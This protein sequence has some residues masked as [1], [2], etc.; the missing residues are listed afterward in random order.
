MFIRP[1]SLDKVFGFHR[2]CERGSGR[3]A[4]PPAPSLLRTDP[5]PP[6]T[7]PER[8]FT[9][10]PCGVSSA[11]VLVCGWRSRCEVISG[12]AGARGARRAVR[13]QTLHSV[14][15]TCTDKLMSCFGA[16]R[17]A[18]ES[19]LDGEA[20]GFY[21]EAFES[22]FC[23]GGGGRGGRTGATAAPV[24]GLLLGLG[25]ERSGD[26]GRR[27]VH[28]QRT[29]VKVAAPSR[30]E[31]TLVYMGWTLVF[32]RR[33]PAQDDLHSSSESRISFFFYARR[34]L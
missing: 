29:S 18:G 3:P 24:S 12:T 25:A 13:L 23:T 9:R 20:S 1:A 27:Q 26:V 28:V 33:R 19:C 7:P 21:W 17:E 4:R 34:I 8:A 32:R 16:L 11:C 10:F 2:L 6:P 5:P 22:P 30:A 15:R 14:A 31:R